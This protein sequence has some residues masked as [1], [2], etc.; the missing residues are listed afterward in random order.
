MVRGT[1]WKYP[2]ATESRAHE[3]VLVAF[4]TFLGSKLPTPKLI[5]SGNGRELLKACKLL[6][7]RMIQV[8]LTEQLQTALQNVRNAQSK[9][10]RHVYSRKL[11]Y[12]QND[13][14]KLA[15]VIPFYTLLGMPYL[16]ER[17]MAVLLTK[18][19]SRRIVKRKW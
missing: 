9:K 11:A 4:N 1:R 7:I 10:A 13:G 5:Y 17:M 12:N 15:N 19:D 14:W 8:T 6:G 3:E 18:P 2:H 16:L